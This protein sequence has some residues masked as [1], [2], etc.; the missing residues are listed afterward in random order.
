[1]GEVG[2]GVLECL[3]DLLVHEH[4][5]EGESCWKYVWDHWTYTECSATQP[6]LLSPYIELI[7]PDADPSPYA[8]L[9][10]AQALTIDNAPFTDLADLSTLQEV[11]GGVTIRNSQ[12]LE[13]L[14]GPSLSSANYLEI[15]NNAAL[16]DVSALLSL[17]S[18]QSGSIHC[19][20]QLSTAHIEEVLAQLP[21]TVNL[22]YSQNGEDGPC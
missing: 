20:P 11:L 21:D 4:C 13:S 6:C 7:G 17:E 1:M 5:P 18:V 19:N 14:D 3:V 9:T 2:P 16:T 8:E 22:D 12:Q 15:S 10:C